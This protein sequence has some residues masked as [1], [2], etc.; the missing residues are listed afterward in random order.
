MALFF[1]K[2][3]YRTLILILIITS[4]GIM[5]S[6]RK[7][8]SAD[9]LLIAKSLFPERA[10]SAQTI[11]ES[12][13]FPEKL[14]QKEYAE[15]IYMIVRAHKINRISIEN[16]TLILKA[17]EY[18]Q[19]NKNLIQ[20][21]DALLYT[22]RVYDERGQTKDAYNYYSD[23]YNVFDTLQNT[24][25][26]GVCTYEIGE[27]YE[28]SSDY[29]CALEWFRKAASLFL[30]NNNIYHQANS[31]RKIGDCYVQL[32]KIDSANFIYNDALKLI[33]DDTSGL[34]SDIYKN[35]AFA[36]INIKKYQ[37]AKIAI[38]KSIQVAPNNNLHVIH[39]LVLSNIYR[40]TH[41]IDS[42]YYFGSL[43]LK[44]ALETDNLHL[45][46]LTYN[47]LSEDNGV[48]QEVVNTV[49][50]YILYK[51]SSDSIYQRQKYEPLKAM[52][53][54]YLNEKIKNKN[55][56]LTINI[57]RI[58]FAS[59][60]ILSFLLW[61]IWHFRWKKNKVIIHKDLIIEENI[62]HLNKKN[63]LIT[64][65]GHSLQ[66]WIEFYKRMV[67][68]SI[69]P[70]KKKYSRFLED[71]NKLLL[72]QDGEF[73]FNWI[74][75]LDIINQ[76]FPSYIDNIIQAFPKLTDKDRQLILMLKA[77]FDIPD[78]ATLLNNSV[79]TIYMRNSNIRKKLGMADSGNIVEYIDKRF[80]KTTPTHSL[81]D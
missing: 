44:Y 37:T 21:G 53:S 59:I 66:G 80:T 75:L 22:G 67:L 74:D 39:Y 1:I 57:Q 52:Q 70:Q 7:D 68:L 33:P 55:K 73:T 69:S 3:I 49:D 26:K 38:S 25:K 62:K 77:G 71:Y 23:A 12:I 9:K 43:S 2:Q 45:L 16:D 46:H 15:Y 34:S 63:E 29:N 13:D 78:I 64:N 41:K 27:L 17:V 47:S 11:L 81:D 35:M 32:N 42:A 50:K 10:D 30:S 19:Q 4:L 6:C 54:L 5:I 61:I 58:T 40:H 72:A 8:A 20:L 28:D 65:Y 18:F 56:E 36:Y 48:D 14:S 31:L 24:F 60:L 76:V 79:N 51:S